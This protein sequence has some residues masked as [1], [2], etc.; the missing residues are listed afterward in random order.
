[1]SFKYQNIT[2]VQGWSADMMRQ[3]EEFS[4]I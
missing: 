3:S 4:L 2:L 1:M